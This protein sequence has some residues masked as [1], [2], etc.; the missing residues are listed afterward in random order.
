MNSPS[1]SSTSPEGSRVVSDT[2]R[3]KNS[4]GVFFTR[5]LF[6]E[7]SDSDRTNCLYTLRPE[8]YTIG[9]RTFP[10]LR[11]LYLEMEDESEYKFAAKYFGGWPHWQKLLNTPWFPEYLQPIRDEL[12]TKLM[13]ESL[14]QIRKKARSGDY[15]A[16]K[17]LY[18]RGLQ[19]DNPV[20]RPTKEKIKQEAEKIAAEKSTFDD[21]IARLREYIS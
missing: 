5:Q 14:E 4:Q 18:E 7:L 8:D 12:K 13:A 1:S 11:R 10:S 16:N 15:H 3:F 2:P 19:S 6:I 9:G 21:D 17:Y 20:G